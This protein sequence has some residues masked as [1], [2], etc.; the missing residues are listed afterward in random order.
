MERRAFISF[1]R[2]WEFLF[3]F[4]ACRG[5]FFQ[6]ECEQRL[7][8]LVCFIFFSVTSLEVRRTAYHTVVGREQRIFFVIQ[9]TQTSAPVVLS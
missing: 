5:V 1:A 7:S 3:G 6:S 4:V 9:L 2:E 8:E